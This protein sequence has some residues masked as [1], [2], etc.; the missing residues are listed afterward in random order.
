MEAEALER[1]DALALLGSIPERLSDLLS[2]FDATRL[3]YRHGP[4]FP[5]LEEILRHLADAA[6]RLDQ[7]L[8]HVYVDNAQDVDVRA[9]L[10]ASSEN[11]AGEPPE[12]LLQ[13]YSRIRRRTVDLLRGLGPEDLE[14][15]IQDR[16][17]GA[18]T[19]LDIS[20]LVV[21]HDLGHLTQLR[22]LLALVPEAEDVGSLGETMLLDEK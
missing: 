11:E 1:E 18:L 6:Q 7:A 8:R 21:T 16:T 12:E 3:R 14:R 22:N 15:S 20:R 13:A 2:G 10:D 17:V 4:A 19:M 9:A 5:T